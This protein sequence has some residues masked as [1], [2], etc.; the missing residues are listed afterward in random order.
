[1]KTDVKFWRYSIPSIDGQGWGIFLLDSTGMFAAVSDYGNYAYFWP[2][3]NTGYNDFREFFGEADGYYLMG[4]VAPSRKREYQGD[5]TEQSIRETI[6]R[7]RRDD[8]LT[9]ADA[10]MEWELLSSTDFHYLEG[11]SIW[12][13]QTNLPDAH[14]EAVYDYSAD[15]LAFSK[16]LYPRFCE[17]VAKEL[18]DERL[19]AMERGA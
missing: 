17:I 18:E 1:M 14:E 7:M 15:E 9:E 3:K 10:R 11:F 16:I 19:L 6:L 12:Y 8:A 2:L 4:K 5:R 13:Q